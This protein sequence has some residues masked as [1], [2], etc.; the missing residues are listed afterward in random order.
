M[1]V[2]L[3]MPQ[4]LLD[5]VG[6]GGVGGDLGALGFGIGTEAIAEPILDLGF[7]FALTLP[8]FRR[9]SSL[10]AKK[11]AVLAK[12][13]MSSTACSTLPLLEA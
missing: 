8:D 13:L 3:G 4:I 1:E 6:A 12:A 7:F 2:A 11:L 5:D 9:V 10:L